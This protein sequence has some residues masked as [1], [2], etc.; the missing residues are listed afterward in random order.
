MIIAIDGPSGAGKSTVSDDL[1]KKLGFS[2]LDTGAM[3]RAVAYLALKNGVDIFDGDA[4]DKILQKNKIEFKSN[5][6]KNQPKDIYIGGE[7]VSDKIRNADVN[8]A[9]T[10]VCKHKKV[11][12]ALLIRQQEIAREKDSILDGRDIGTVVFPDA[13]LKIFLTADPDIR[14]KRRVAQLKEKGKN[15]DY[16]TVLSEIKR[17]DHEDSTREHAP[18]KKADDAIE[19]DTTSFSQDEVVDQ[20]YNLA[21]KII[22]DQKKR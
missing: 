8:K 5:V 21:I 12:A 11:R 4:L 18:L 16:D 14:A 20:I 19:I 6:D 3:F 2:H 1:A 13:E 15:V 9:V 17:R 10:P 7:N 22:E